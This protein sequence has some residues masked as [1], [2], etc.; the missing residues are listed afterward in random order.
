VKTWMLPLLLGCAACA[1]SSMHGQGLQPSAAESVDAAQAMS[2]DAGASGASAGEPAPAAEAD[3]HFAVITLLVELERSLEQ[4]CPCE[5]EA[6]Q[7]PTMQACVDAVSFS[8]GWADCVN[9]VT[10]P[11]DAESREKLRCETI[12]FS[13]RTDCLATSPCTDDAVAE[14]LRDKSGCGQLDLSVLNPV[15]MQCADAIALN[16]MAN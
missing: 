14:C 3:I 8:Q 7:F 4:R 1:G 2:R 16:H 10:L 11:D 12:A 15:A 5:V 13:T 6:R 9:R